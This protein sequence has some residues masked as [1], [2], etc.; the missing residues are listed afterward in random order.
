[1]Y[2]YRGERRPREFWKT[3]K[4]GG[5]GVRGRTPTPSGWMTAWAPS[6]PTPS[7]SA[8]GPPPCVSPPSISSLISATTDQEL[9]YSVFID[10]LTTSFLPLWWI[11]HLLCLC[12]PNQIQLGYKAHMMVHC[13]QP[14]KNCAIFSQHVLAL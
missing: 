11:G 1:M 2:I 9:F 6:V 3:S 13:N 8:P 10:R 7:T 5:P 14:D 12:S 4:T